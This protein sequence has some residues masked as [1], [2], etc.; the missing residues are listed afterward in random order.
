MSH[1]H[2][3]RGEIF[4]GAFIPDDYARYTHALERHEGKR[5]ELTLGKEKRDRS[6]SQLA[7]YWKIVIRT[8]AIELFGDEYD[9]DAEDDIHAELLRE[10][11]VNMLPDR[12][13]RK[14]KKGWVA[15][16]PSTGQLSLEE[17]SAYI[18]RAKDYVLREWGISLPERQ[19]VRFKN[20]AT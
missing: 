5:V 8:V 16:R 11:L 4:K 3:F 15:S 20:S 18:D 7:Y 14:T 1:A 9:A 2:V 19:D 6:D 12:F 10:V 17:M 13:V